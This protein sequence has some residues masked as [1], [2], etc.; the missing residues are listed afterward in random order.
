MAARRKL[1]IAGVGALLLVALIVGAVFAQATP[2]QA[3]PGQGRANYGQYFLDRLASALG[4]SRDQLNA[5]AKQAS[6][7]TVDKAQADGKLTAEQANQQKQRAEQNGG[8]PNGF[9]FGLPGRPDQKGVAFTV[10]TETYQAGVA[11]ALGLSVADLQAQLKAGKSV[12]DLAKEKNVAADNV[13]SAVVT[14]ANGNLDQQAKDGKMTADQATGIKNQLNQIPA[15]RFLNLNTLNQRGGRMAEGSDLGKGLPMANGAAFDA[16][17]K[18]L[19]VTSDQLRVDLGS[20]KKLA[21][22]AK[23]KIVSADTIKSAVVSAIGAQVDQAV[24]DGKMTAEQAKTLK[25]RLNNMSADNFL[26]MGARGAFTCRWAPPGATVT[27]TEA[28]RR[29]AARAPSAAAPA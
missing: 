2:P 8:F 15:D 10:S 4:I 13:K 18:A 28:P 25:D 21:D 3:E 7:E 24:T 12:A 1:L 19:N 22:I 29:P 11:Q 16:V 17:A 14:V 26:Q 6:G 20:G 5:A 27:R 9:G 23:E